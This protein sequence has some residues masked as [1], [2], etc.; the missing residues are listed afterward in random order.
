M[1]LGIIGTGAYAI[2]LA[3]LIEEKKFP[4]IMW[5]KFE[6][7][8]NELTNNHTNLNIINYKLKSNNTFTMSLEELANESLAIIIA[9]PAK[10]LKEV[11]NKIKPYYH[12]QPILIATKGLISDDYLLIHEYLEKE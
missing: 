6:K 12:N 5:T 10:Y 3:S 9:I 1:K 11:I 8:Y 4:T 7:E 2:A